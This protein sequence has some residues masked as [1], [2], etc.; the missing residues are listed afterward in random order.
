MDEFESQPLFQ[1]LGAVESGNYVAHLRVQEYNY[2]YYPTVFTPPLMIE[3]L[4]GH[5]EQLGSF[6]EPALERIRAGCSP[7]SSPTA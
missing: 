4:L 5:L 1:S 7:S 2:W 6:R 3:S